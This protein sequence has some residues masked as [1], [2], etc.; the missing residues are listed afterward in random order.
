MFGVRSASSRSII[1]HALQEP[2]IFPA[3]RRI[4]TIYLIAFIHTN[5]IVV[6]FGSIEARFK[7][8]YL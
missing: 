3:A 2:C 7:L 5:I 4:E 8:N 1:A 6:F